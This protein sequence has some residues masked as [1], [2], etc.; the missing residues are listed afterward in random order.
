MIA[1]ILFLVVGLSQIANLPPSEH[2]L[3]RSE[4]FA[5]ADHGQ[6]MES[7]RAGNPSRPATRNLPSAEAYLGSLM[8]QAEAARLIAPDTFV[9]HSSP[10]VLSAE[11]CISLLEGASGVAREDGR[12]NGYRVVSRCADYIIDIQENDYRQPLTQTVR[13]RIPDDAVNADFGP[14]KAMPRYYVSE[15]GERTTALS[16]YNGEQEVRLYA[17]GRSSS[18]IDVWNENLGRMMREVVARRLASK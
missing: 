8:Q 4:K 3:R 16:W 5:R 17:V 2:Q 18:R 12:L 6:Q 9:T 11:G 13:V 1:Q 14:G 7:N 15:S 10:E